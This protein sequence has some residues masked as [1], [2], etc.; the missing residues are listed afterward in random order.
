MPSALDRLGPGQRFVKVGTP[1]ATWEIVSI[2]SAVDGIP[3]VKLVMVGDHSR[4]KTLSGHAL[5]DRKLF[6]RI[7][8]DS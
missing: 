2:H 8:Q 3:L 7:A 6:R 4:I 1:E 5:V